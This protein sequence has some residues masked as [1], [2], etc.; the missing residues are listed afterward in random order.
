MKLNLTLLI[1]LSALLF[2]GCKK[3][4]SN[5]NT[6]TGE[7]YFKGT[8][9]G[10]ALT[11]N[12]TDEFHGWVT[13][14]SEGGGSLYQGLTIAG[15]TA[16][17]SSAT[18]LQP[19]LGVEF[20]TFR[21]FYTD[22]KTTDFYNFVG[23]GT[24]AYATADVFTV[25]AKIVI[26]HYTDQQG[27]TYSSLGTQSGSVNILKVTQVPPEFG[28]N[29]CLK[30]KVAFSCT[31]YPDDATGGNLTLTNVDATVRLEDLL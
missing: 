22:D 7:Y 26:I 27:K 30:I 15:I 19:Q 18:T 25:G 20:R 16:L 28:R 6:T 31:L 9:N 13:G 17:I 12:V 3:S 8:L 11:W 23:P 29:E 2:S 1:I 4:Q 21:H 24:W 10:K 5:K 14:S